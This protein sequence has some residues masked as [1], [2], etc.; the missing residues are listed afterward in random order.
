MR[1]GALTEGGGPGG[2]GSCADRR[3]TRRR[4]A[5]EA[6]SP[7]A[8]ARA[9]PGAV[10]GAS[11]GA[12]RDVAG[13]VEWD[14]QSCD[15]APNLAASGGTTSS[16]V[17]WHEA[18]AA[19]GSPVWRSTVRAACAVSQP[20]RHTSAAAGDTSSVSTSANAVETRAIRLPTIPRS[21]L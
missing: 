7:A 14:A 9:A 15:V 17:R 3:T 8:E 5:T 4:A 2:A 13:A 21:A 18:A 6:W 11:R 12:A 1:S 10:T 19:E 16:S 20:V